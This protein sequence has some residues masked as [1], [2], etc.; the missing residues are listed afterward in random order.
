MFPFPSFPP[1]LLLID[2][3]HIKAVHPDQAAA[4]NYVLGTV[5]YLNWYTKTRLMRDISSI[6]CAEMTRALAELAQ[7]MVVKGQPMRT[8]QKLL[9]SLEVIELLMEVLKAP[10]AP[11][12]S[13]DSVVTLQELRN[14]KFPH[15]LKVSDAAY[16]VLEVFLRGDSRKNEL[17]KS[18]RFF[19]IILHVQ[20]APHSSQL[21]IHCAFFLLYSPILHGLILT[22]M[23]ALCVHAALRLR[24]YA[25]VLV[26]QAIFFCEIL[27]IFRFPTV[28]C[29]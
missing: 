24:V 19:Y 1:L 14:G 28:I 4:V 8:R 23:C 26:C 11:A 15:T 17:C 12:N 16:N 6:E 10:F 5:G 2:A 3:Y 25:R 20:S 21:T 7:F 27:Y 18:S 29:P 22:N 13:S 9:R